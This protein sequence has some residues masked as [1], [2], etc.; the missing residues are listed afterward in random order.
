MSLLSRRKARRRK[1]EWFARWATDVAFLLLALSMA[2]HA[3][4]YLAALWERRSSPVPLADHNDWE[5]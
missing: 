2:A 4:E 3:V 1:I 5:A